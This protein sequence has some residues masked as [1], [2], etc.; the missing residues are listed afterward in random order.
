MGSGN[1][2]GEQKRAISVCK[3]I[4]DWLAQFRSSSQE[5]AGVDMPPA[6]ETKRTPSQYEKDMCPFDIEPFVDM[7][8]SV[9]AQYLNTNSSVEL[10]IAL[11]EIL[12]CIEKSEHWYAIF[13]KALEKTDAQE[14]E[15]KEERTKTKLTSDEVIAYMVSLQSSTSQGQ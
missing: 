4:K 14:E 11:M 12:S 7:L 10:H 3:F 15:V 8:G 5:D 6:L 1:Q 13:P 9:I 2:V